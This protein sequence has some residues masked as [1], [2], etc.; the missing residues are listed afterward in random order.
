MWMADMK[1]WAC[2]QS[3]GI[4]LL[5]LLV[6]GTARAQ[7]NSLISALSALPPQYTSIAQAQGSGNPAPTQ[8]TIY[9]R[10]PDDFTSVHTIVLA[11]G[12][13]LSDNPTWNVIQALKNNSKFGPTQIQFDSGDAFGIA[14]RYAAA[15]QKIIGKVN[16]TVAAK[17]RNA[18]PMW[19]L[20]CSDINGMP[21]ATLVLSA[22]DGTVVSHNGFP[23][24][25]PPMPAQ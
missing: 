18:S 17:G 24:V 12:Q 2:K 6:A 14:M 22:A 5:A 19:T 3:A 1:S 25:P 16:Y 7:D 20:Q 9:A 15:N 13:V 8:W 21:M 4:F 10:D 11:G 23:Q